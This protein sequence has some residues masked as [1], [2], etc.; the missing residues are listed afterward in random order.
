MAV[1]V[2]F[3]VL[4]DVVAYLADIF[5]GS[6]VCDSCHNNDITHSVQGICLDC[7]YFRYKWVL[8]WRGWV[9]VEQDLELFKG[10]QLSRGHER[11]VIKREIEYCILLQDIMAYNDIQDLFH[12]YS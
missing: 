6:I 8:S 5:A 10:P 4:I 2:S 11:I 7:I 1:Y 3:H 9:A 12:I